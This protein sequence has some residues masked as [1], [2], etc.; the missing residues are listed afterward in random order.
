MSKKVY[1]CFTFLFCNMLFAQESKL[2]KSFAIDNPMSYKYVMSIV[3]DKSGFMWFGGQEGLHRF[4]GHQLLSFYHDTRAD[5]SLSSNVISSM[6]VDTKHR[7]WIGTRGGGLNLYNEESNSFR[8]LTTKTLNAQISNDGVNTLFEDSEGKIWIGTENGLNILSIKGE[9]WEVTQIQHKLGDKISLSHNTVYSITETEEHEVWIGTNGGGISVFGLAGNFKR[10]IKYGLE[11]EDNYANKYVN[12]LFKDNKGN[13]WIGTVDKGLLKYTFSDNSFVHYTYDED[14]DQSLSSNTIHNIYQDFEDNIWI[15]TDNGLSIYNVQS[16]LFERF[17]YTANN[18]YSLSS[19]YIMSFFEDQNGLMWIGTNNGLN[20]WDSSMTTFRQYSER[21]HP[22]IDRPNITSFA[23]ASSDSI[24]FSAYNGRIYQYLVSSDQIVA[25]ELNEFFK[26]LRV[27]T[28][29]YD[30]QSLWVGTRS[31]GLYRVDLNTKLITPFTHDEMDEK[32]ISANSITDII[33]DSNGYLWVSTFYQGLNRLNL[34]GSFTRYINNKNTPEQGPSNN[35]ILHLLEGE[36]GII[37]IATYGGGLSR[38]DTNNNKFNHI[39]NDKSDPSS[40]SSDFAW[41]LLL[42]NDQNLWVSTQAAGINILSYENRLAE[43]YQFKRIGTNNGMKSQTV[44]GMIQ[45]NFNDIWLSSN[46]GITRYSVKSNVFKHFDLS[47]GLVDLDYN[48][49]AIF[50]SLDDVIYFGAGK[51]VSSIQPDKNRNKIKSPEVRLTNVFKLNEPMALSSSISDLK[52]LELDYND[53]LISFEYVGLNYAYPESTEY[54]YRLLGFDQEWI[55]AGKS[56]RVTYTNLPAGIFQL[57]IIAGNS[58]NVWSDPGYSLDITVKP[59]PWNTW[60]AY[61]L[62]TSIVALTLLLYSRM[63]NRKLV[64]EQQQKLYLEQQVYEKTEKFTSKNLEL[65]QANKQLEKAA[66]VDKVTGVKSRRYLDI[67]IEQTS[68]LM[69]QM[70][71]NLLPV[72]REMLPRLYILM[73]RLKSDE[74][75]SNSQLINLTDLL[76][77]S[78]NNDDLVIRWSND[79][80]AVIGYEKGNNANELA[81][82]LS[83]RLKNVVNVDGLAGVNMAYSFFPFSRENPLDLSWDQISVMIEQALKYTDENKQLS[84]LGLCGPKSRAL[85]Y[86]QLM[87]QSSFSNLKEQIIIK[88]GLS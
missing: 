15:A 24:Y 58:D 21:E 77:Y 18:N 73:V 68:Q 87:Q 80:F 69:H 2:F 16:K 11:K 50:K 19:N 41:F 70:H 48:H 26:N 53:Q 51:G 82:R 39:F 44:Y 74:E 84:W 28:L 22:A 67:Y 10:S 9:V 27:M 78:R 23:Q 34:D 31:S 42:D 46:Q 72:Q 35:S 45:D 12:A 1:L 76:H 65:A 81:A 49:G 33:K 3:Q 79:T 64:L 32:T 75:I 85:N 71:Q 62:Y 14:D 38:F 20:R 37:W 13:I 17:T 52:N 25:L 88:S 6:I 5:S 55:D 56:R 7:L 8:H 29:F 30:D 47:H 57:Q 83:G 66:I 61:I 54:K 60:W 59:A 4:D 36:Q 40:L 63:L 43:N 86:L